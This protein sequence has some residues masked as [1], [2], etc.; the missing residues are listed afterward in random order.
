MRAY[1]CDA[2]GEVIEKPNICGM[3]E[4]CVD[5][6]THSLIKRNVEVHLCEKCFKGLKTIG[7]KTM[8]NTAKE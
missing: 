3:K 8:Q 7:E 2:C 4:Y 1:V 5:Y 6:P